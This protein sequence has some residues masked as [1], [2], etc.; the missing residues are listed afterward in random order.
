[1]ILNGLDA[2]VDTLF[3]LYAFSKAVRSFG[4]Y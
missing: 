2:D 3:K 4:V 1:M